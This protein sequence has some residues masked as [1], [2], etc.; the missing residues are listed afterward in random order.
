MTQLIKTEQNNHSISQ[1][2]VKRLLAS[3]DDIR[4]ELII[5]IM[6]NT[7]ARNTELRML[8]T[9]DISF[10]NHT[11]TFLSLKKRKGIKHKKPYDQMLRKDFQGYPEK[12]I[13][14]S[15]A[16]IKSIKQYLKVYKPSTYLFTGRTNNPLT[17][18][19]IIQI[20]DKYAKKAGIQRTID[21]IQT[22]GRH[23]GRI[24]KQKLVTPHALRHHAGT[25]IMYKTG[26]LELVRG[27]LDHESITSTQVY[28]HYSI[29]QQKDKMK[30]VFD[31]L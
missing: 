19:G 22:S 20:V 26:D 24:T 1:D 25:L 23:I 10:H 11:L 29:D 15:A 7:G 6:L 31:D 18:N 4:H 8:T 30:N 5:R 3:I 13:P 17:V 9:G 14:V 28:L 2:D 27:I 12:T 16:L 21:V